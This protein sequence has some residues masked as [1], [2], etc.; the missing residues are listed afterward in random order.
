MSEI[1]ANQAIMKDFRREKEL[2]QWIRYGGWDTGNPHMEKRVQQLLEEGIDI[3]FIEGV[4]DQEDDDL[5]LY[6]RCYDGGESKVSKDV[7]FWE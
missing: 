4:T 1:C 7:V 6:M 2:L 3:N 5:P